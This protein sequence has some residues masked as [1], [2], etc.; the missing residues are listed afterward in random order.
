MKTFARKIK[1]TKPS[2][3]RSM[4]SR[5]AYRGNS[6][7]ERQ[8]N[9]HGILNTSCVQAKSEAGTI[10]EGTTGFESS[11]SRMKGGG[12]PL[13]AGTRAFY[14]PRFGHNFSQV[15]VHT[16]AQAAESAESINAQ[17]YTHGNDIA[18]GSQYSPGSGEGKK[19][20]A[21]ELT[22]VVQQSAKVQPRIQRF[23]VIRVADVP[24]LK[25]QQWQGAHGPP[26]SNWT[27]LQTK[28]TRRIN[29]IVAWVR[30]H[31]KSH[32]SFAVMNRLSRRWP[33]LI[34]RLGNARFNPATGAMPSSRA[35]STAL[36]NENTD[37]ATVRALGRSARFVAGEIQNFIN[38]LGAY[39]SSRTSLREEGTEF[40]RMDN[41][42]TARDVRTL[43]AASRHH[44]VGWTSADVKAVISQETGDL[45]DTSV[46]GIAP[47]AQGI[48]TRRR[49]SR[50]HQRTYI[51][52]GQHSTAART[53]A[54]NWARA[55]GVVIAARPDPRR[56][57]AE[58]IKLT[59]AYLGWIAD[60][61]SNGLPAPTP[62]NDEFKKFVFAAYNWGHTPVIRV[63][64]ATRRGRVVYTW[65]TVAA[66]MRGQTRNY[67]L[68][69]VARLS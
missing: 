6:V 42:F 53:D 10:P 8:S 62:T 67:V 7:K 50:Q 35:M 45:T 69:T 46:V 20:L 63:T 60:R 66:G 4:S 26:A 61:M 64:N 41:L 9:I 36:R 49:R 48:V 13:D 5:F 15:R 38:A 27:N 14:E 28:M 58:A 1:R 51:G 55:H 32:A 37:L 24:S 65:A 52:L 39:T 3:Q 17:A 34:T 30:T 33:S 57:P 31:G 43:V 12:Q 54:I 56:T 47:K 59:A 19:L 11:V 16:D 68:E 40:H 21:H 23:R 2:V 22:H 25:I 29:I 44:G 18:F